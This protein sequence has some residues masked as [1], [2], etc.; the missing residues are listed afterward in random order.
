[1]DMSTAR[2]TPTGTRNSVG[3]PIGNFDRFPGC[4]NRWKGLLRSQTRGEES[5][6]RLSF[7]DSQDCSRNLNGAD[8]SYQWRGVNFMEE[9]VLKPIAMEVLFPKKQFQ[10]RAGEAPAEPEPTNHVHSRLATQSFVLPNQI[11]D[12]F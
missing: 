8:G 1:M 4:G 5:R 3:C 10:I 7:L 12:R 11:R 9:N 6:P 2:T